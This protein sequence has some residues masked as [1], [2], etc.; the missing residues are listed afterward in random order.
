MWT[1]SGLNGVW[2]VPRTMPS[3]CLINSSHY[4]FD[5]RQNRIIS[6]LQRSII[7]NWIFHW[8]P[9]PFTNDFAYE[10]HFENSLIFI[11]RHNSVRIYLCH[12]AQQKKKKLMRRDF[13]RLCVCGAPLFH[14]LFAI[15]PF[16]S[17]AALRL[18]NRTEQ[19][20]R[21][22]CRRMM[23]KAGFSFEMTSSLPSFSSTHYKPILPCNLWQ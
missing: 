18:V 19:K 2:L 22:L 14:F 16:H 7:R 13:F 4:A 20:M 5:R 1:F 8:H 21:M 15:P 9:K 12:T 11:S 23:N 10:M 17:F 6:I 3:P